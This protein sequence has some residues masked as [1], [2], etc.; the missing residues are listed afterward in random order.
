VE[1]EVKL[2]SAALRRRLAVVTSSQTMR[3]LNGHIGNVVL[4]KTKDFLDEMSVCRHKV[5]D[6][7]G[8]RHSKFLEYASGR[9]SG[10]P[11]NQTTKLENVSEKGSTIA[12]KNTPGL[13]RAQK[14]LH[15]SAKNARAL[16][17]PIDRISHGK[18]VADLR[19]SGHEVFRPKGKNILAET[20]GK[21]KN[22]KLRPLFALVKSVTV[23]RDRGL[24]PTTK[25]IREWT[26]DAADEFLE[27]AEG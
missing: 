18:R 2:D 23:P 10:S 9:L 14:D 4:E 13:S 24:L 17:I 8:A 11:L 12:I 6:R 20:R 16:T 22:A 26:T 7:L 15:I 25:E 19:S 27:M 1:I 5:A 21:G 3:R